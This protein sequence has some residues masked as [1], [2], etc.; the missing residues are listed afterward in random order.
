MQ[1]GMVWLD[2]QAGGSE[3]LFWFPSLY[4]QINKVE[5]N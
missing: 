5:M 3:S 2:T 1:E 4:S